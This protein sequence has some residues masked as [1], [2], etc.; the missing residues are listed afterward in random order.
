M[1]G[2]DPG[3]Q[4]RGSYEMGGRE[5]GSSE[6]PLDLPLDVDISLYS[7]I[8]TLLLHSFIRVTSSDLSTYRESLSQ[9]FN[10]HGNL[11]SE[12]MDFNIG[13]ALRL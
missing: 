8:L 12:A 1:S 10:M 5:G 3:F 2:A 7:L 6:P 13:L 11:S 4:E 9:S